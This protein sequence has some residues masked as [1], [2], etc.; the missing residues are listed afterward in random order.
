MEGTLWKTVL[1]V[2]LLLTGCAVGVAAVP[3]SSASYAAGIIL[4]FGG[5]NID[6]MGLE[7]PGEDAVSALDSIC[8]GKGYEVVYP[9]GSSVPSSVN[10][11]PASG[12]SA[13]WSLFVTY[14]GDTGWT[15]WSGDPAD[16]S[17]GDFAAVCWGLCGEG[18]YPT[19]GVDATGTC[20]YG[21]GQCMR[22][23]SMSPSC[24]ETIAAA[25]AEGLIVAT[26]SY[27]NYPASV[28]EG[29]KNG[30]ISEIGG[31]TN[32]SFETVAAQNPDLV[33]GM[34]DQSVHLSIIGKMRTQ[35]VNCLAVYDASTVEEIEVNTYMIGVACGYEMHSVQTIGQIQD[36]LDELASLV[37]A[38]S[39]DS[40]VMVALSSAKS[41]W[42]AGGSTYVSDV[43]ARAACSN[44]YSSLR[45]WVQVNSETV[46]EYNPK[47][48]IVVSSDY[49]CSESGYSKML[50]SLSAE[51]RSTDAYA[52]GN[53]YLLTD[54]ATDLASRPST[55]IAQ[56]EEL[57]C[58]ILQP[59]IFADIE[60]P[61]WIGDDYT[62]YLTYTAELGFA[63]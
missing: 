41:P 47:C 48:I 13:S 1:T 34:G 40:G 27:S 10:S 16:V 3:H 21:Y 28:T 62:D 2:A 25:G 58:R 50:S 38:G 60:I 52:D 14:T 57:M 8:A 31:Y 53:I 12:S 46:A 24:T 35:G 37:S 33:I 39:T 55:R 36:A 42:V 11:L 43:I 45:G 4:D 56:F 5:Y 63:S 44:V 51:W 19:P 49:E 29:K 26:D 20:Y 15:R 6:Y 17:V 7:D 59:D 54:G 61:H 22:I 30:S 9:E 23:V 18:E 32:P